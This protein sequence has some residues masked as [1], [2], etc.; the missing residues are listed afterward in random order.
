ML[1]C[2]IQ[3]PHGNISWKRKRENNSFSSQ[4]L[5]PEYNKSVIIDTDAGKNINILQNIVIVPDQIPSI[6]ADINQPIFTNIGQN[7]SFCQLNY[8]KNVIT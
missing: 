7:V 4:Q 1:F 3:V 8:K 2:I 6:Q 5:L